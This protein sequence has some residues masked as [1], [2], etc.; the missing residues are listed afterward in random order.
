MSNKDLLSLLILE[1]KSYSQVEDLEKLVENSSDLSALPLQPLYLSIKTM[2]QEQVANLLPKMS[3]EQR[4]ALIDLDAWNKD[5]L[6]MKRFSEW[7]MIY[8][9]CKDDQVVLDFLKSE[10]FALFLKSRFNI[11]T[12]D[13]EDPEYPDHDNYFLTEDNLLLIEFDPDFEYVGEMKALI[14]KLYDDLGVDKAYSHLFKIVSDSYSVL[15]EECYNEKK[16]RLRDFGFVDYHDALFLKS[17]F[18]NFKTL[19]DFIR[20]K[21]SATGEIEDLAKNQ[22]LHASSLA[23]YQNGLKNFLDELDLLTDSKRKD[24]LQFNFVRLVNSSLSVTQALK[25][26]S[27]A[28]NRVGNQTRQYLEIGFNFIH[29]LYYSSSDLKAKLSKQG[30]FE[31]FDF[32]DCYKVGFS[33]ISF[34]LSSAKKILS[35]SPFCKDE[36]EYFLGHTLI[37]V[38]D[39]SF[40]EIVKIKKDKKIIHVSSLE[41]FGIWK[42]RLSF[43]AAII[44][45]AMK[46]FSTFSQLK[47]KNL[48]NDHFY[49]NYEVDNIDLESILISSLINF[50]LGTNQQGNQQSEMNKMGLTV[51]ELKK[52]I[53]DNFLKEVD[54]DHAPAFSE[55]NPLSSK[56]IKFSKEYGL[57]SIHGF[58]LYLHGILDEQ[59]SGYHFDELSN[60]EFK[61][62]GGPIL[63][64]STAN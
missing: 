58:E 34:E 64:N 25:E 4:Q 29:N 3:H 49:L 57:Y 17:N 5:Q 11:Y 37:D 62:V 42:T 55:N 18:V 26:G 23:A 20:N 48:I 21:Q 52:F 8:S 60:E 16:E 56:I 36:F 9:K 19:E 30:L 10:D 24:F 6:D 27:I 28:I 44:P 50:C 2:G 46:F 12:F 41:D 43:L 47:E 39:L 15:E 63:L 32:Y 1:S 33:L 14:R 61:H 38:L 40:S 22:T 7:P 45:Y 13:A 31:I 51:V 59:L 35:Q 54:G 53:N